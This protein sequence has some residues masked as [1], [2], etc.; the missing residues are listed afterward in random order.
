M[1]FFRDLFSGKS[2]KPTVFEIP[3]FPSDIPVEIYREVGTVNAEFRDIREKHK[4]HNR[5]VRETKQPVTDR[6]VVTK[7]ASVMCDDGKFTSYQLLPNDEP[8]YVKVSKRR[9]CKEAREYFAGTPTEA[10]IYVHL[11]DGTCGWMD[12]WK[13]IAS[14]H[15]WTGKATLPPTQAEKTGTQTGKHILLGVLSC[16][17]ILMGII[18]LMLHFGA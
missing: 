6:L 18:M 9:P 2:N 17:F 10:I 5:M 14:P 8:T 16:V 7:P 12:G 1:N 13:T 15:L 4:A 3:P 11:S